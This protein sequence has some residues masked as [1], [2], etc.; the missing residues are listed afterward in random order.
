VK[1][2]AALWRGV[3]SRRRLGAGKER[4]PFGPWGKWKTFLENNDTIDAGK[5][6]NLYGCPLFL[7]G[8]MTIKQTWRKNQ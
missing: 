3:T 8:I 5:R 2:A 4:R 6:G 1:A 7:M